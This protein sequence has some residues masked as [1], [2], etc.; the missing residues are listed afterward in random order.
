MVDLV[1]I[2]V[3]GSVFGVVYWAW[4]QVWALTMPL[5]VIFPPAQ[6]SL[7]GVWMLPQVLAAMIIR[8]PGAALFASLAA[9]IVSTLLGNAFGLTMLLYGVV[10]GLAVELV[11]AVTRFR[12]FN[13]W[14]AGLGTALA[15]ASGTYL[16]TML[17]YPF[18]DPQFKL[19]YIAFG[20]VGGFILGVLVAPF[21]VKR[22]ARAGSLSGLAAG[23][24][25]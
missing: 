6:A 9:V 5:F 10:Q 21:V 3:L 11:F 17:Y 8:R 16:D 7:Y 23:S 15:C 1:A 13:A 4:N 2:S 19:A 14:T 20:I 25:V 24:V 18:W 12:V 22:L